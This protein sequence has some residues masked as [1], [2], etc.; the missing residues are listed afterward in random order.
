MHTYPMII[1]GES[2]SG[3]MRE[4]KSPFDGSVVGEVEFAEQPQIEAAL[5]ST[6]EAAPR[7]A[8]LSTFN[9]VKILHGMAQGLLRRKEE[10]AAVISAEAGKPIRYAE[11][12]AARAVQTF[13]DAAEQCKELGGE[14]VSIDSVGAGRGR[15]GLVRRFPVGP[16]AAIS[17]FNFPLNLAAHKIAPAIAVGCPVVLKPASQTPM[18]AVILGQLAQEAGIP[19]GGLNVVPSSREAA[20]QLTVDE[21]LKLLTFTGS[22]EVGWAMKNR[23]GK[24]RVLLELGG[25][26]AVIIGP[27][28]DLSEV[29][30]HLVAGCFAYA[31]QICI[32]VQRIFVFDSLKATLL[33]QLVAATEAQAKVGD[34]A[35]PKVMVGPMIDLANQQRILTWIEEA[36]AAGARVLCGNAAMGTCVLPTVLTEVDPALRICAEEAFGPIVIVE[37]VNSWQEAIE[38]TNDSRFGLQCG[39]FTNNLRALW[40]CFEGIEVGGVIHNDCPTFRVDHMPYGGVKDSGLGREGP[41]YAMEEMSERRLLVLNP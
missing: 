8:A 37:R 11:A 23:S 38:R 27:D 6:V 29:V 9:R 16:V 24:K 14:F 13:T 20:N 31:G 5:T 25:N 21:R 17:P 7:M 34:P 41:R 19:A 2:R 35:D 28:A 39:V 30:P 33:E 40:E 10:V 3:T 4:I 18:S 36:R 1:N 32:S 22:A 26:A 15:H 12:E